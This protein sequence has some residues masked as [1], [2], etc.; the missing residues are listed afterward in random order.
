[1]KY[2]YRLHPL[3]QADYNEAYE[4]YE[5]KQKGLGERFLKAVRQKIEEI[6]LN[7]HVHPSKSRKKYREAR[8][9]FFPFLIV[10]SIDK[11][12]KELYILSIHNTKRHPL[13]KYR[14]R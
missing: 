12:N 4:W 6:S 10:Y 7:P 3:V 5:N 9:D 8:V 11:V 2:D 14:K 13:K 1:M